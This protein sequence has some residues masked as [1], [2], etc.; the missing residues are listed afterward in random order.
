MIIDVFREK[1]SPPTSTLAEVED[2]LLSV[3]TLPSAGMII[4]DEHGPW[5]IVG[6]ELEGDEIESLRWVTLDL[7]HQ[8]DEGTHRAHRIVIDGPQQGEGG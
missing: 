6:V 4:V 1:A 3:E 7:E 5:R 8:R 2:R